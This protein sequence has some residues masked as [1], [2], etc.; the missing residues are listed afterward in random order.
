MQVLSRYQEELLALT[1]WTLR[2]GYSLPSRPGQMQT[3]VNTSAIQAAL[4]ILS[5]T[6]LG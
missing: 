6:I 5:A 3:R 1:G 2:K 4:A